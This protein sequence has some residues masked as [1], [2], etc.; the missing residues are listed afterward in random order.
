MSLQIFNPT[1]V[2]DNFEKNSTFIP[3]IR[4]GPETEKYLTGVILRLSIFS[5]FY[6]SV[7]AASTYIEQILGMSKSVTLGGT[8]VIILVSVAIETYNQA[9]TRRKTQS[10]SKIKINSSN[11]GKN[12]TKGL[13]W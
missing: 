10:M 5:A 9:L 6:L 4:P 3:G 12:S 7:I 13:I 11:G 2:A 8:S 1:K